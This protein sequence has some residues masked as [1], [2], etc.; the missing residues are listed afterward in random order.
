MRYDDSNYHLLL[1]DPVTEDGRPQCLPRQTVYGSP[2]LES[3]GYVPLTDFPSLL[4]P[5]SDWKAVIQDCH[6][7]KIF[8][9]YHMREAG[10]MAKWY[11]KTFGFCW[12][13]DA[14]AAVM[15]CRAA[16]GQSPVRLSPFSLG[17][18]VNWRNRGYFVD[19]ALE[20]ARERG[21]APVEYVPEYVLDTDEFKP[22][23]EKI[24]LNYRPLEWW[25]TD[26]SLGVESM[27]SQ[28]LGL[29]YTGRC[30]PG[31]LNWWRHALPVVGMDWDESVSNCIVWKWWNSHDDGI[32]DITGSRGVP[33][34]LYHDGCRGINTTRL[35]G[36]A[37]ALD[38]QGNVAV[39]L[40]D[41]VREAAREAAW[42]VIREHVAA[43]PIA[44]LEN[45]VRVLE[46]RFNLLL[47]AILG[48]GALGGATGAAILKIF[49]G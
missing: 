42:T 40:P 33:D 28:A 49:G 22:G 1:R 36:Y 48:S 41:Y 14:A 29:L 15:G 17:W 27:I 39:P 35:G 2:G 4:V 10:V 18:L 12:A 24:A 11:Q 44:R 13:Y 37:M 21:L 47:G 34:E 45:R 3:R 46:G 32:I 38:D 5:K 23:W 26:R 25:D 7:R 31:A 6:A 8:P 30:C 43:C 9:M 20:G 16:E 19:R